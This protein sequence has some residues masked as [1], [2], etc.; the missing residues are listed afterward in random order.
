MKIADDFDAI[1]DGMRELR[2]E[3]AAPTPGYGGPIAPIPYP[4]R[5][6]PYCAVN[7]A[8]GAA[9]LSHCVYLPQNAGYRSSDAGAPVA[10]RT[11][12]T[13]IPTDSCKVCG[14]TEYGFK[15]R[16]ACQFRCNSWNGP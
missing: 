10:P 9:H 5:L 6:C 12:P 16:G 11:P 7:L 2:G 8:G 4:V 3:R 1:R 14:L 15:A 13:S